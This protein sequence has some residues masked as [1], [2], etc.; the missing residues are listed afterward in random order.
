MVSYEILKALKGVWAIDEKYANEHFY[1]VQNILSGKIQFEQAEEPENSKPFAY[2]ENNRQSGYDDAPSGS[3]AIVPLM[4]VMT[5]QDQYCGPVGTVNV[6]KR[7]SE[8][9]AHKNISA[10]IIQ[11]DTGGGAVNSIQPI[12]Q[13]IKEAQ[14][15][16]KPV[17]AFV[18]DLM[19]SAG[20][21]ALSHADMII[22]SHEMA[23]IGSLGVMA[24]F[25]DWQPVYEKEGVVF[26]KVYA[27][28]S[29]LKNK[30]FDKFLEG[31]YKLLKEK[32]LNPLAEQAIEDLKKLRGSKITDNN[33]YKA[34]MYFAKDAL[35]IGLIDDIGNLQYAVNKAIELSKSKKT[36]NIT[37]AQNQDFNINSNS[38][39]N[40]IAM[41]KSK[42][43][44]LLLVLGYEKLEL[45]EGKISLS[46][47]DI[48]KIENYY[49]ENFGVRAAFTGTTFEDDGTAVINEAGLFALNSRITN[50]M[51]L[52][53]AKASKAGEENKKVL[54]EKFAKER[55]EYE[56]KIKKLSDLPEDVKLPAG[57]GNPANSDLLQFAVGVNSLDSRPWNEAAMAVA[58]GNRAKLNFIKSQGFSKE[59]ID[60]F[61]TDLKK[62]ESKID[63]SQL[64]SELGAYY[65]ETSSEIM[66]MLVESEQIS[67]L[68]P[69]ASSG[70]Q[71]IYT[72]VSSYAS[73]HLQARNSGEWVEKGSNEF[74]AESVQLKPWQVTRSFVK[75][76]MYQLMT[77]WLASKTKGTN[78]YQ[79]S[80]VQYFITSILRQI[81]LVERPVNAIRGV[82]VQPEEDVAGASINSM[83]GLLKTLQNLIK[84]NRILVAKVGKGTHALTDNDGNI[85]Q[86]NVYFKALDIFKSIP[87]RLRDAYN[88]TCYMS[89]EDFRERR[90]FEKEMIGTDANYAQKESAYNYDNLSYQ[91]VPHW[92]DGLIVI[93]IPNNGVQL[94]R[95]KAD[96]NR[97]TVERSKRN[98]HVFMDGAY[99]SMWALTGK[100][101]TTYADLKETKGEFQRIFT[102]GEFGAYTSIPVDADDVTPSVAVHNVLRT[103]ANTGATVITGFDDAVVGQ[104]I[105]I[106]GGSNTNSSQILAANTDFIGL[107]SNLTLSEGTMLEVL[108]TDTDTY[109]VLSITDQNSQSAIEFDADDATP[110]VSGGYMFITSNQNSVETDITDF[111]NAIVGKTFKVI[112]GGGTNDTTITKAGKFAYISAD[113]TGDVGEEIILMKRPDGQFVEVL[114]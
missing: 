95:D 11:A 6:A 82:Y 100:K 35:K 96:D 86:D 33:V 41:D 13:A 28:Q 79:E 25:A 26:H 109:T 1:L 7:I 32:E 14:A 22:A 68:F 63:I 29:T 70:I 106:I 81:A 39:I 10:I 17:I 49:S 4:G 40:F 110:D 113:W 105:Y 99:G 38:N 98:T 19:A 47:E 12:V 5:K 102:N 21:M 87:Q 23:E 43:P 62:S 24:A 42:I 18:D 57:T 61:I 64:N 97:I 53:I 48:D 103:S 73:E 83:D 93:T 31:D 9:A 111:E 85:N 65:R 91:Q 55:S 45:T 2:S 88:W 56:A 20:L 76:Q 71:D 89:K 78:P 66:D 80:F 72:H 107:A 92:P 74:Q 50:Q 108:V 44:A 69:W 54:E 8:A 59:H 77:S 37:N 104:K 15:N 52:A 34:E 51:N 27:D 84:D 94:Y 90:K 101:F 36:K 75:E 30:S 67:K 112:G 58:T 3:V 16:S 46:R 114:E 60:T